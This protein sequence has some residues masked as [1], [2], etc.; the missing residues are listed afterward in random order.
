[1]PQSIPTFAEIGVAQTLDW[2]R[3][4]RG[5]PA[6]LREFS[7]ADGVGLARIALPDERD[8]TLAVVPLFTPDEETDARCD[9]LAHALSDGAGVNLDGLVLWTPPGAP[10]PAPDDDA[11]LQRIRDAAAGLAPGDRAEVGFPVT[12]AIR[13]TGDE[14]SYLSVQGGLSPHWARFT[15][16]VFGQLQLDSTALHR[17]PQ[18]PG[19]VTQ[20]VDF[21]VLVANG[22]RTAGNTTTAP[23]EDTWS[24]QRLPELAGA[25]VV[26]AA[27]A[28]EA[29]QGGPVRKTLRAGTRAAIAALGRVPGERTA[30]HLRRRL[31]RH[32]GRDGLD[33]PARPGS[34]QLRPLRRRLPGRGRGTARA[35]RP[36]AGVAAGLSRRR[37][38]DDAELA[39]AG[40]DRGAA[41]AARGAALRLALLLPVGDEVAAPARLLQNPVALDQLVEAAQEGLAVLTVLAR[42]LQHSGTLRKQRHS[43]AA[44]GRV[45]G[46]TVTPP[47]GGGNQGRRGTN[48]RRASLNDNSPGVALGP[49]AEAHERPPG[50]AWSA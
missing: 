40:F 48:D 6:E 17:L 30:H 5:V 22:I 46:E 24:L 26:A 43:T 11:T 7:S 9:A 13:K 14:G 37:R 20:L 41:A 49:S 18:D 35:V 4:D 38:G 34:R 3:R 50:C 44:R 23:A 29:E 25:R 8:A 19:K 45:N 36:H 33:R 12:L 21:L 1:M 32:P 47:T 15:N 31:P 10:V 42:D 2:L 28:A 16:Q 39:G 27:P